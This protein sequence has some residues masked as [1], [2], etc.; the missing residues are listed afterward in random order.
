MVN[1]SAHLMLPI[2]LFGVACIPV[3]IPEREDVR[4]VSNL[5]RSVKMAHL[6]N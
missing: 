2:L 4:K 5:V 6:E 3:S 1:K